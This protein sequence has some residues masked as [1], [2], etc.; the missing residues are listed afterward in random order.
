ML[1]GLLEDSRGQN[2][3]QMKVGEMERVDMIQ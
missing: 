3:A 1:D 2:F